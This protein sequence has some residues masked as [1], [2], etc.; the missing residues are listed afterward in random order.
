MN[1]LK[2]F[3]ALISVVGEARIL[4]FGVQTDADEYKCTHNRL[5][6]GC[7]YGHVTSLNFWK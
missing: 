4:K 5:P 3:V 7:V 1:H 2:D 6:R